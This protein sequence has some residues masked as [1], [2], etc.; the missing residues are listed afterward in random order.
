MTSIAQPSSSLRLRQATDA[1]WDDIIITDAR[2][3]A[4]RNPLPADESADLRRKVRNSDVVLVRDESRTPAP[5]VGVSMFYR[6]Q[7]TVP[8]ADVVDAAALSWVSVASTHRRRG[9]LRRMITELFEQWESQGYAFAILTASEGTIY[10]RFGF[11]PACFAESVRITPGEPKFRAQPPE[12]ATVYFGTPA[13][14]AAAIPDIHA[15]WARTRPGALHRSPQWWA[16]IL[17][18]RPSQR[19]PA[20]SGLH[21]LLHEDGYASY[22]IHKSNSG[23]VRAQVEEFFAVTEQAHTELW[24]VLTSLDLIPSLTASIPVDDPLWAKITDLRAVVVTGRDDKMWV[25]ILDVA[26]A[27]GARR[28][29]ADL[30]LVI[31]VADHFRA[32]GGSYRLSV[33]DGVA[34]VTDADTDPHVR[35]DIS[36]L[37]SLFLGGVRAT[38]AA[39]AGR[40]SADSPETLHALD[41]AFAPERAP[42]AGTFF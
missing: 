27:L 20:A 24:R 19:P 17:A 7:M 16:P 8:G 10:E 36:T 40:L 23:Q 32:R 29:A 31:E 18:D 28:Y 41:R 33:R 14:V 22:R 9:I 39:A 1:D 37:S 2:A 5:L 26:T 12:S 38:W 11:G 30:D 13:Q 15:R 4:M 34:N 6:M 42:F 25:S 35:V 3:F 21:Y